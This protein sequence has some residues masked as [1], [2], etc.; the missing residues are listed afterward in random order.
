VAILAECPVCHRK[1][2]VKNKVC[3]C[4]Q[5]LDKAKQSKRV[6]YWIDYRLPGGDHRKEFVSYSIEDA[7]DAEA[8]RRTQKRE[9][10]KRFFA[11]VE[12]DKSTFGNLSDWY[13]SLSAVQTRR[14][15]NRIDGCL[16]NVKRALGERIISTIKPLDL[17]EYQESRKA[18]GAAPATIDMELTY[19]KAVV[20]KAFDNDKVSGYTL[21]AF[22][23][24]KRKLTKGENVRK[25]TL[26]PGE[27]L[28]L[29][30]KAP[31]HLRGLIEV[32]YH[33]GMRLGELRGLRWPHIDQDAGF[34]RLPAEATKEGRPKSIPMNRYVTRVLDDGVLRCL[35]HDF[36]F[37]FRGKPI[38]EPGGS[39]KIL[40]DGL[41]ERQDP[42]R[43]EDRERDYLPRS[44]RHVRHQHGPRRCQRV[45]PKGDFGAHPFRDGCP[46]P[47]IVRRGSE[48]GHSPIHGLDRRT[49]PKCRPKTSPK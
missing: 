22:Q 6:R 47:K 14:T 19:A 45:L 13:L 10:G 49:I 29:L 44:P 15:H 32:A 43:P 18:K 33:T 26:G 23:Q 11:K 46:L 36:V 3:S 2:A 48:G 35:H 30:E 9:L 41:Q 17:E 39:Q 31:F 1:Q 20:R 40:Q 8:K 16:A 28:T 38:R 25:R 27:Y 5:D 7:R 24:Y 4:G 37:S 21:K 12:E 34:I 42:L